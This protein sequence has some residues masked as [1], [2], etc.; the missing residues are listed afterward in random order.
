LK[1]FDLHCDTISDCYLDKKSLYDGDLQVSL[2]R[3]KKYSPWFQCF[4][5]WITD[6][7]RGK[8]ALEYFDSVLLNFQH[9]IQM[10][11]DL[12]MLCKTAA[13]FETAQ[14]QNKIGAI[15]TV[16]GGA[17]AA[18]SLERLKYMA[19]CGVKVMTLTWNSSCEIGDGA[20]GESPH[21]LTDFGKRAVKEMEHLN[22]V[23]DVS[24]ASDQLFYDVVENT[25][26]PFIA[27]HSNSRN[28][29]NHKRNLT[30]EQ[31]HLIKERGGLVGIN[32]VPK[33]LNSSGIADYN[34]IFRHIDYFLSLGGENCIA[35]GSDFD[36]TPLPN[37]MT[38][39]ESIE[40]IAELM[41]R[42]NYGEN[43]VDSV[44]FDNAHHFFLS[45]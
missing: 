41:L 42:H 12:I 45:L 7:R 33:F 31:F 21:G 24:H 25:Q 14:Q 9:E 27:T 29:C 26:K 20:G 18:G 6:D 4:A 16:E 32:F 8:P 17:A 1:Y 15:L 13:D 28:L 30:D 39:I 5:I 11:S 23:I 22:M 3:G 2:L 40:T 38:G 35:F 34:D 43:L 10:H 36:G 37:G 19:E 44:L